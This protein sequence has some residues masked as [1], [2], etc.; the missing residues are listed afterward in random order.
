MQQLQF[1][2]ETLAIAVKHHARVAA[3]VDNAVAETITEATETT[4]GRDNNR[5]YRNDRGGRDNNRGYRNDRGGRDGQRGTF[6]DNDW[7]CPKCKN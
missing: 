3:V 2:S 6:A 7:T 5:G 4:G 1:C